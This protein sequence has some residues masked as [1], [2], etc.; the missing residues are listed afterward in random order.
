MA[1]RRQPWKRLRA[2]GIA[3]RMG[4][5]R[6]VKLTPEGTRLA[7]LRRLVNSMLTERVTVLVLMLHSSSLAAGF[8]PY[9]RDSES[10]ESL[11]ERMSSII[12]YLISDC[13]FTGLTL[14]Q[15]ADEVFGL[16]GLE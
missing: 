10:L 14:T 6:R 1:L 16:A 11:Y 2:A 15:A 4:I 3:D 12:R 13:G 7:D 9:A 5:A 8:S